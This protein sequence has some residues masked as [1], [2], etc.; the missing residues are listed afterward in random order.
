MI[1]RSYDAVVVH[2]S[3]G[4]FTAA[5]LAILVDEGATAGLELYAETVGARRHDYLYSIPGAAIGG[6]GYLYLVCPS[7][8]VNAPS[9]RSCAAMVRYPSG[10]GWLASP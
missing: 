6:H 5:A 1:T 4:A 7:Q 10:S 8:A 3:P 2:P 9:F